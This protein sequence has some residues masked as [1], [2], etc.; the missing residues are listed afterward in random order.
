MAS[1]FISAF[2]VNAFGGGLLGTVVHVEHTNRWALQARMH[3]RIQGKGG[4]TKECEETWWQFLKH[5][6]G[7]KIAWR[8][9]GESLIRW[10]YD[11]LSWGAGLMSFWSKSSIQQTT[12]SFWKKKKKV[13]PLWKVWLNS[14]LEKTS[15]A[16]LSY[17]WV[18]CSSEFSLAEGSL[19]LPW[20]YLRRQL[21]LSKQ[22]IR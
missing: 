16:D 2:N 7:C 5:R 9:W 17:H 13:I 22:L 21:G 3:R 1:Q 14:S 12:C 15:P 20:P 4:K 8:T 10:G 18:L 6:E 19:L 11:I